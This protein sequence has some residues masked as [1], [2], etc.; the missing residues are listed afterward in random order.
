MKKAFKIDPF[1]EKFKFEKLVYNQAANMLVINLRPH[2][3]MLGI[4]QIYYRSA[5]YKTYKKIKCAL[6]PNYSCESV[7]SSVKSSKIYFNILKH[8]KLDK[9]S[10]GGNWLEIRSYDLTSGK[11]RTVLDESAL[12]NAL[13]VKRTWVTE[14]VGIAPNDKSLYCVVGIENNQD[15]VYHLY[16]I[17]LKPLTAKRLTLLKNIHC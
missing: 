4:G 1:F 14:L 12:S 16:N 11:S 8:R 3:S 2:S 7:I 13:K 5:H 15:I 10:V 17:V 6:S 9:T